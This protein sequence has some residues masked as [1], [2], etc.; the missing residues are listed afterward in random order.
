ML[1]AGAEPLVL[2]G[3][4]AT[5]KSTVG[6]RIA[7]RR[8]WRFVDTDA[9][10]VEKHGPIPVIFAEAGEAGFRRI[11]A[12]TVSEVFADADGGTVISLGGGS[13]L[14][15]GT[16]TLLASAHV[17]FLDA[18]LATVL[19]RISGDTGRPLLTGGPGETWARLEKERRPIYESLAD[20][21]IDTR[22]ATIDVVVDRLEDHLN[23]RH[24]ST[25]R[26]TGDD[27]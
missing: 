25:E 11:E 8:G 20:T 17:V 19:P 10:I 2:I 6:R 3:L 23:R 24:I 12:A 21:V 5:G 1:P 26:I 16:R 15:Q 7:E 18:D 27:R 13:V 14:N 9:A 4:M 22:G